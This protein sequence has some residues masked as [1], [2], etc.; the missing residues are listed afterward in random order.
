[1][2]R[3]LQAILSSLSKNM[4]FSNQY[5]Q[6]R[7]YSITSKL[8]KQNIGLTHDFFFL[9]FLWASKL[10]NKHLFPVNFIYRDLTTTVN[11]LISAQDQL[12][13]YLVGAKAR[14]VSLEQLCSVYT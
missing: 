13:K 12:Q 1:M 11:L 4:L 2:A 7:V 6:P 5:F 14:W 10:L 3:L 9:M 8:K